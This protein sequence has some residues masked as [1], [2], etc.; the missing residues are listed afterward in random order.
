MERPCPCSS[1][2]VREA[3]AA[4]KPVVPRHSI[5]RTDSK[6]NLSGSQTDLERTPKALEKTLVFSAALLPKRLIFS[7]TKAQHAAFTHEERLQ[8]IPERDCD[9]RPFGNVAHE[10]CPCQANE[11]RFVP[12]RE[13]IQQRAQ[14]HLGL[15]RKTLK[16]VAKEGNAAG[17]DHDDGVVPKSLDEQKF[18]HADRPPFVIP[19]RR[20]G[21]DRKAQSVGVAPL[22]FGWRV[23]VAG[24]VAVVALGTDR[25]RWGDSSGRL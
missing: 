17:H 4:K 15:V 5:R 2:L 21:R 23:Q 3:V 9:P 11:L 24:A 16:L 10:H 25:K 6:W 1:L 18:N 12:A 8:G 19:P 14:R 22:E 20:R 7:S 13:D